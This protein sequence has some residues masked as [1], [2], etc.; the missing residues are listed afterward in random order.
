MDA[1]TRKKIWRI[2]SFAL[3]LLV[4][5]L[6]LLGLFKE[7]EFVKVWQNL[8]NQPPWLILAIL[9]LAVLRHWG[10][11]LAWQYSLQV[12]P[13][14]T[15]KRKEVFESYMIG[16]AL[17]FAVPGSWGILGKVAFVSNSSKGASVISCFLERIYVTWSIFVFASLALLYLPQGIPGW[18]RWS[19][20]AWLITLPVWLY[21]LLYL[22]RRWNHLRPN[23]IR[24]APRLTLLMVATTL[25]NLFQYWLMLHLTQAV[26]FWDVVKRMSL[27][28][29]SYSIP[30]TVAGLG[31]KESFA[32]SLLSKIGLQA[33]SIASTTLAIFIINDVVPALIGAGIFLKVREPR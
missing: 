33:E 4:T 9:G 27:S 17:R 22:N 26:S 7:M 18:I 25:L 28:H 32:I 11:Y 5:A 6:I 3:K 16:Q 13:L 1:T 10:Q 14:Y 8:I 15:L 20:F 12:N 19:L 29:L 24:Y 23:Y 31:L 2:L 30:I 21:F